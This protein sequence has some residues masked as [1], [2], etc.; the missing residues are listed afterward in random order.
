MYFNVA[1]L[2]FY[3]RKLEIRWAAQGVKLICLRDDQH[4]SSIALVTREEDEP[5]VSKNQAQ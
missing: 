3:L 1:F 2:S 5:V 4:V